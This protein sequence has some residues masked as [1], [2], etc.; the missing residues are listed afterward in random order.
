MNLSQLIE[1]PFTSIT[2]PGALVA[3]LVSDAAK[4]D[5]LAVELAAETDTHLKTQRA[6]ANAQAAAIDAN[7]LIADLRKQLAEATKP[8]V[9]PPVIVP[10]ITP[11]PTKPL[12]PL[13]SKTEIRNLWAL[14]IENGD[15]EPDQQQYTL[16][17]SVLTKAA[18]MK[19]NAA[20]WFLNAF[21][22][23]NHD[24]RSETD[25]NHLPGFAR[26]LGIAYIADTVDSE[27]WRVLAIEDDPEKTTEEKARAAVGLRA[28]LVG[29]VKLGALAF[30]VNDANTYRTAKFPN[31]TLERIVARIRSITPGIPLIA[32]L[33]GNAVIAN[34][35]IMPGDSKEVA[36]TKFDFVEAQTF[37]KLSELKG[38]FEGGFDVY[39]LDARTGMSAVD[40]TTRGAVI[41]TARPNAIFYYADLASDWLNMSLDKQGAL[42]RVIEGL[43]AGA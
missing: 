12:G 2:L 4:A 6:L 39:C 32:S 33:T 9:T 17:R 19:F 37:G 35:K 21:E 22:V 38:F 34:Y 14:T 20:R 18:G 30:V 16:V 41:L 42:R 1:N 40:I 43:R 15:D 11:P 24:R 31:G 25:I 5:A 3:E 13:I 27:V 28:Y 23:A 26:A 29:L 36:A 7:T 10:P 8:P